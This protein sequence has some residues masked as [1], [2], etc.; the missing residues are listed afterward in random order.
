MAHDVFISYAVEDK[1]AADAVCATLEAKQIRCW[2]APRD[3]LP[4]E[5]YAEAL[6]RAI[7]ESRLLVLVFSS[8]SNQSSHVA[9]ELERAASRGIPI[10]PL[11]I[12]D[13][14]LSPSL[15]YFISRTHWL[16]ALTPPLERHLQHLAETVGMLLAR[17]GRPAPAAGP[18]EAPVSPPGAEVEPDKELTRPPPS[19]GA[20][21]V[22]KWW[23]GRPLVRLALGI[24]AIAMVTI[25]VLVV[26]LS[27]G[28][29]GDERGVVVMSPTPDEG[30]STAA[31]TPTPTVEPTGSP[32]EGMMFY[33]VIF[34]SGVTDDDEPVEV[35]DAFSSGATEVC[36]FWDY[37]GMT[38]G[39][40]LDME[41]FIDGEFDEAGSRMDETW[42]GGESGNWWHCITDER[43]LPDGL[44]ELVLSVEGEALT[45]DAVFVGGDHPLVEL[46]VENLL[47]ETICYVYVSPVGANK[48]GQ[49]EMGG[50]DR[51]APGETETFLIPAGV[52]DL[53]VRDCDLEI[54]ADEFDL[55]ISGATAYQV[56]E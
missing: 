41:W 14:P 49:D 46:S 23:A 33:N 28:G 25:I 36:A 27:G 56:R 42:E 53:L 51:I 47:Q 10:L 20:F 11:R 35:V 1:S 7:R 40:T 2:I 17:I 54:L 22:A 52:Y 43:G 26:L 6:V 4:G 34:S 38:D 24:G 8:N 39:L 9:R 29:D 21:E 5:E 30:S 45:A 19:R 13:V 37:E 31:V 3:V 12:E 50:G 48:W 32:L 44:Y 18:A 16:D 15:E 55:D